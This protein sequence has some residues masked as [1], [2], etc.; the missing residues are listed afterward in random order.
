MIKL[1]FIRGQGNEIKDIFCEGVDHLDINEEISIH[2]SDDLARVGF[3]R[4]F[5]VKS[6]DNNRKYSHKLDELFNTY[7][8][9]RLK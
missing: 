7:T 3:V 6:P 2:F 4:D 9:R 8:L 5:L 1:E